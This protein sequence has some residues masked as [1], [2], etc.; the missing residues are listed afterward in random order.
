MSLVTGKSE[1]EK[2]LGTVTHT[3]HPNTWEGDQEFIVI[4]D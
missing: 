1:K 2:R 3:C 4:H